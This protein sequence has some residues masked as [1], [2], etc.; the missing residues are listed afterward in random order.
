MR[1]LSIRDMPSITSIAITSNITSMTSLTFG[2]SVHQ[3]KAYHRLL[4]YMFMFVYG[5]KHVLQELPKL[6][7]VS[8]G[9]LTRIE[10][11][12]IVQ[13]VAILF[14]FSIIGG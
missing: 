6:V 10:A 3:N 12:L 7:N 13:S 8:L 4:R 2:V 9:N 1:T 11:N 14:L 5:W